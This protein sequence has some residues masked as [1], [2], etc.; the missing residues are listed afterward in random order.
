MKCWPQR[1]RKTVLLPLQK[2]KRPDSPA[3][4]GVSKIGLVA[5]AILCPL[6]ELEDL[7]TAGRGTEVG[8]TWLAGRS[9]ADLILVWFEFV[10]AERDFVLLGRGVHLPWI[11]RFVE[12]ECPCS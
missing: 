6:P 1:W 11:F 8:G 3:R 2:R 5:L 10:D 9:E 4:L 12:F 7:A